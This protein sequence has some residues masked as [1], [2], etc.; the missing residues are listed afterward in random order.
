M[1]GLDTLR[2][3]AILFVIP[4]HAWEILKWPEIKLN[5]GSFGWIGV[6]LF[7]VLSGFLIGSQLFGDIISNKTIGFKKFYLKRAF[8]ILPA[9]YVVR[10]LLI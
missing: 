1:H 5:F 8:R 3:I 9:Y 6:D 2:A 4:R 7:F 10:G